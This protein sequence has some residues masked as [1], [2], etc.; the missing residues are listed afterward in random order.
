MTNKASTQWRLANHRATNP[1]YAANRG[2]ALSRRDTRL[3]SE[4]AEFLVL[5]E[6]LIRGIPGYKAYTNMPG[7][8]VVALDPDRDTIARI[9]VKSRWATDATGFIIKN[10]DCDFVVVAKLNCGTKKYP[11]KVLPPE[12][13]VLPV[14]A[15]RNV[16]RSKGWNRMTFGSIPNFRNYRDRW[17]LIRTF[18]SRPGKQSRGASIRGLTIRSTPTRTLKPARMG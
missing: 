16:R 2:T 6:L 14:E 13:Y 12:F 17:D 7:Y 18:L 1:S 8:D 4:G 11:R 5:G 9:S 10:F 3:E 15:V